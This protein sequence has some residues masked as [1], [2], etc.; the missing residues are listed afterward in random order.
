MFN[1][2]SQRGAIEVYVDLPVFDASNCETFR[3]EFEQNCPDPLE[4]VTIDL[5]RVEMIDSSAIGALLSI[6]KR[7]NG[8]TLNQT[9]CP[10]AI[11]NASPAVLSVIELLRL[12]RVFKLEMISDAAA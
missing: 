2:I 1:F 6:H 4:A 12:H 9:V 7:I 11:R 8:D 10:V 5:E 3:R